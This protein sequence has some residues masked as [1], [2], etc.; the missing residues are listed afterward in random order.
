MPKD[1]GAQVKKKVVEMYVT[2]D[3]CL[4]TSLPLMTLRKRGPHFPE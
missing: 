4:K 1:G 2:L 3:K